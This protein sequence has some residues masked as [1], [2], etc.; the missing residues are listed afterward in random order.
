[1]L[2][3]SSFPRAILHIDGDSFFASC[4]A[5]LDPKLKGKPVVTG[6]ERGI[7]SSMS[8]EAK[9]RGVTRGMRLSDIK[10]VCPEAIIL[11]SD[12]ETYSLFSKRMYAI[13]GRYTNAIEEYSIDECFAELTG[14]RRYLRLPYIEMARRIKTELDNELGMTFS[15][16]L[17][18]NKVIAKIGSKWKKPNGLTAIPGYEIHKYLAVLPVGKIWGIGPNTEAFLAQENVRTALDFVQKDEAWVEARLAKPFREIW[19]ELNG[20]LVYEL[21]RGEHHAYQSISKT[22]TFTPPSSDKEF[23]WSQLSR[24][25][26]NACIK[27]RRHNLAATELAIF[28]KTQEFRYFGADAKLSVAVNT[29]VELAPAVRPLFERVYRSGLPYRATGIVLFGLR[30]AGGGQQDL[31]GAAAKAEKMRALFGCLD[32]LDV[33]YGKH[34]VF[35][36]SSLAA[37]E[38]KQHEG[39]RG[40]APRRSTE[41]FRGETKRQ[42]L[43]LPILGEV[44]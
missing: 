14:L 43:N 38:R 3:L 10:K 31:F 19:Q 30:E 15:V 29:P 25:V 8:Y 32:D 1:M 21:V 41:L 34:T 4:E 11:P 42:H 37:L 5:A 28:L 24:N 26:E 17:G 44:G 27:A 7:A 20:R 22:K 16:G 9:A 39:D 35:L 33:R 6:R 13:V 40:D 12:Y 2:Q 36:G 18:P 23:V